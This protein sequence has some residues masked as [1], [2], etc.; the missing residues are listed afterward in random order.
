VAEREKNSGKPKFGAVVKKATTSIMNLGVGSTAVLAAAAL[1]SWPVLA[2]GGVA[3]G[4]MVALDLASPEFWKKALSKKP[5]ADGRDAGLDPQALTDPLAREALLQITRARQE[6]VTVLGQAAPSIKQHLAETV[7]SL[8]ELMGHAQMLAQ[9]VEDLGRYL[10]LAN[11]DA[12]ARGIADLERDARRSQDPEARAQYERARQARQEQ[13][14]ALG[15]ISTARERALAN[16][17]RVTATLQGL[18]A[19]VV[20]MQALD[21]QE[22]DSL[23]FDL[24]AELSRVNSDIRTFEETLTSLMEVP[25]T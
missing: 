5:K 17:S 13:Q 24:N 6:L 3:Y 19:Q 14:R 15:D 7:A 12:V 2:L 20:R 22:M 11:P 8:D 18:P 16:L 21:D 10:Q 1:H 25:A 9:R 4:A 23:S